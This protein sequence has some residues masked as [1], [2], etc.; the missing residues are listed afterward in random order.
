M[1]MATGVA[2]LGRKGQQR[3]DQERW[4]ASSVIRMMRTVEPPPVQ[5]ESSPGNADDEA[6]TP[7]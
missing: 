6:S 7:G 5:P 3:H 2:R 4:P 1:P